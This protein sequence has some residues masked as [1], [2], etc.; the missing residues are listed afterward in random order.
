[1]KRRSTLGAALALAVAVIMTIAA[2]GSSQSGTP[3]ANT[4]AA[5]GETGGAVPTLPSE[6]SALTAEL[7]A[8]T[9]LSLPSDL[10]LPSDLSFPSELTGAVNADC[11]TVAFA[12]ASVGLSAAAV[13][14]GG[15]SQFD[16]AQL[17][18][19]IA[20]LQDAVPAEVADDVQALADVAAQADGKSLNEV[21]DL[22]NSDQFTNASNNIA[23][24]LD[25][26]CGGG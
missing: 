24:W 17:R 20:E 23:A 12:Y 1:M 11:L 13:A 10:T 3:T 14:L 21:G 18:Q 4:T 26:N 15:S 22:L 25:Q 19:S 9:N 8:L 2:C 7:S 16:A 5:T 6:L